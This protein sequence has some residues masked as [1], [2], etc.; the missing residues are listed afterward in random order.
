[1]K[2][3]IG[4]QAS[5]AEVYESVHV[6]LALEELQS[7]YDEAEAREWLASPQPLL[8]Y[9]CALDLLTEREGR[10]TVFALIARLK[11]CVYI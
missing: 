11:D 8:N 2:R 3:S 9:R 5:A 10:R 4:L 1:M 7:V 6:Q